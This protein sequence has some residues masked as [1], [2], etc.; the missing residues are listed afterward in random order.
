MI[1]FQIRR[2]HHQGLPL[3]QYLTEN[4]ILI[5]NGLQWPLLIDPHKQAYSWIRQ[6]EGPRLQE[7]SAEDSS[8]IKK[9]EQAMRSG[10]SVLLQVPVRNGRVPQLRPVDTHAVGTEHRGWEIYVSDGHLCPWETET[11]GE[12]AAASPQV[13]LAPLST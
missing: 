12:M 6:M 10:G 7:L 3:G 11:E 2:W 9:I 4:A 5:K 8:S 13:L 1:S